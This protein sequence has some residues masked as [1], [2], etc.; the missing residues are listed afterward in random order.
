MR[1]FLSGSIALVGLIAGPALAAD[2]SARAPVYKAPA[3][4]AIFSWTGC[5]VGGNVGWIRDRATLDNFPSGQY[6]V[7]LTPAER[8][9]NSHSYEVDKSGFT[10]GLQVGCNKQW[11]SLVLGVEADFNWTGLSQSA[12]ATYPPVG[13]WPT[14]TESVSH[15]LSWFSTFR[16]RAGYAVDRVLVY[17]TGG[18]AVGRVKS[19]YSNVIAPVAPTIFVGSDSDTRIGWTVG[20]GLE[21]AFANNWTVKA[22]YLYLDFG[23]FSYN[24]NFTPNPPFSP[25]AGSTWTTDVRSRAQIIRVGLNYKFDWGG[26]I[27]ASY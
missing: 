16:A 17:A 27:V 12:T 21:Y 5:Y 6:V 22:E 8:A 24:S 2:L 9:L 20:G 11:N 26:P 23:S 15:E 4:V 25:N 7:F 18:L 14:T 1:T 10:G 19:S 13:P 3:G